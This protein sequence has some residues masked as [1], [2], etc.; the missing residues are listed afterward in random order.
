M[1]NR[2]NILITKESNCSNYIIRRNKLI[3]ARC[4]I[5]VLVFTGKSVNGKV[6]LSIVKHDELIK[7]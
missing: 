1:L 4:G 2:Y 6:A 7:T 3:P 5:Y